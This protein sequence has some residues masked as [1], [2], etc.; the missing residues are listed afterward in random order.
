M[1]ELGEIA[2][3]EHNRAVA[4]KRVQYAGT[5]LQHQV[6]LTGNS[7]PAY[8]GLGVKGLSTSS[9]G[10][11]ITRYTYATDITAPTVQSSI[12]PWDSRAS[13]TYT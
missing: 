7:A 12:G 11:L 2:I 5:D 3:R 4:A 1:A 9:D 10:W 8:I 6:E 13:L